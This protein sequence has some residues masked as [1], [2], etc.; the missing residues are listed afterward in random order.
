MA[1]PTTPHVQSAPTVKG[2]VPLPHGY[3]QGIVGAITIFVGF[4]LAFLRF[5]AFEAPG[6]WTANAM[7]ATALLSIPIMLEIYALYRALRVADDDEREYA[8]TVRWFI[9]AVVLMLGAVMVDA[10]VL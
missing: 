9:L 3:R 7:W 5:W 6:E 1:D 8:I 10:A 2:R 4:S